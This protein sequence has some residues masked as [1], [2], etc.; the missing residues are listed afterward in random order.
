GT[1]EGFCDKYEF[2][3]IVGARTK[4]ISLATAGD[5]MRDGAPWGKFSELELD[6]YDDINVLSR[7]LTEIA[8]D[9]N[10]VSAGIV[11]ELASFADDSDAFGALVSGIQN[12][13]TRTRM[14]ALG[15]TFRRLAILARDA[16][17]QCQ[18]EIQVE[19]VGEDV[20][21]D[22][23]VADALFAPMLHL[24]RNA[25]AHGIEAAPAR[26]AAGKP[27]RGVVVLS[28]REDAGQIVVEVRD[29]GKGLDLEALHR[30]GV[31]LGLIDRSVPPSDPRVRDL[32]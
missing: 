27:A 13:V 32:V 7:S 20:S 14:V 23:A 6:R 1:V 24:V 16:A 19:L 22:R 11:N 15:A 12:E 8:D 28:A 17:D 30:R 21:L 4:G 2:T 25:V 3:S 9:I 26:Q 31:E 18:R 5:V 29:D 10:Q